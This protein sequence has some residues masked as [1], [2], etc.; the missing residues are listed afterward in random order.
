MSGIAIS[1]GID[2]IF[3]KKQSLFLIFFQFFF[4]K[5]KKK[6]FYLG[7]LGAGQPPM[8]SG[9]VDSHRGW[10]GYPLV[11]NFLFFFVFII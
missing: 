2:Y 5:R 10:P 9:V 7:W 6:F 3:K 4:Q 8:G 11:F 1:K